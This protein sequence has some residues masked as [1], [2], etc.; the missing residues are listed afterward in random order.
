MRPVSTDNSCDAFSLHAVQENIES[1]NLPGFWLYSAEQNAFLL[2]AAC[3]SILEIGPG[4]IW[5]PTEEVFRHYSAEDNDIFQRFAAD[6]SSGDVLS[7]ELNARYDDGR[8]R[9]VLISGSVL[10]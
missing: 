1:R 3:A 2:D 6:T 10:K 5:Y 8:T 9:P 7:E 4:G